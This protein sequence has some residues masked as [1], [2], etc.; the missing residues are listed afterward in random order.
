MK[1]KAWIPLVLALVLGGAAAKLTRDA[2]RRGR[3]GDAPGGLVTVVTAARDV[4]PGQQFTGA[5]LQESKVPAAAVPP[6]AFTTTADL[7]DRVT[8]T[9]VAKGQPVLDAVLAPTGAASGVQALI[10]RGMRAITIQV[11]EFTGVAGLLTPGCRVDILSTLR[12]ETGK[13]A[14]TRTV[15][16]NVEV[17]AVGQRVSAAQAG[18]DPSDPNAALPMSQSVTLL[19]TPAQAETLQL[20]STG[21]TPWLVLRNA[22]DT[23]SVEREGTTLA[24]L[25]GP[26]RG[27]VHPAA[28]EPVGTAVDPFG[29]T[30]VA[31]WQLPAAPRSRTVR[32]IRATREENVQ[33]DVPQAPQGPT[34]MEWITNTDDEYVAGE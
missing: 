21:G 16:Q 30:P 28:P 29:E 25:R 18:A 34:A 19:V 17:R 9:R 3:G 1:T 14:V 15:A 2:M 11:N 13:L 24:D 10:P 7:I 12:D 32:I 23:A 26:A 31:P 22:T 20:V 27:A 4:Q 33:V 6:G 8:V 5:D